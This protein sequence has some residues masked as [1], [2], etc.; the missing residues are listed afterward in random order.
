MIQGGQNDGFL[1]SIGAFSDA[2]YSIDAEQVDNWTSIM[3]LSLEAH[4]KYLQLN[5]RITQKGLV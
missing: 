1:F 5:S 2:R 3:V 4:Y